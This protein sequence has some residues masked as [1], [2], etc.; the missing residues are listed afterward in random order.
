MRNIRAFKSGDL[1][2]IQSIRN[3]AF[4]PTHDS[5]R[6]L[7]GEDVFRVEFSDWDQSTGGVSKFDLCAQLLRR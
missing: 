7:V 4:Q 3:R 2:L 5:F 6:S 1:P